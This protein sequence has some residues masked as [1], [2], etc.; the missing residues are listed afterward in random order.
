MILFQ[1][2]FEKRV[3]ELLKENNE[4]VFFVFRG[5]GVEQYTYLVEHENAVLKESNLLKNGYLNLE[6]L[7]QSK[8]KLNKN[9][10]LAEGSLIGFYE[11]LIS[12]LSIS[13]NLSASFEGR[14]V[15]INN[16]LFNKAIPSCLPYEKVSE[17]FD[18]MQSDKVQEQSEMELIGQYYSDAL[19]LNNETALLYLI[20]A[21]K[22]IDLEVRDFFEIKLNGSSSHK[23]K[24][25]VLLGTEHDYLFRLAI[26]DGHA[27]EVNINKDILGEKGI[28]LS[29]QKALECLEIPY[30]MTEID[31]KAPKFEYDAAQFL[32]YLKKYWGENAEFRNLEFYKE[33]SISKE[34]K[35][36]SQGSLIS[37]IVGQCEIAQRDGN[38]RHIFITA[39]TGAGKSLLF[40]LPALYISEQYN[41]VTIVI[42]PLIA[43]MNDQVSQLERE[44]GVQIA[45]CINSSISFD[46][47]IR[48]QVCTIILMYLLRRIEPFQSCRFSN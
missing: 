2:F 48:E 46:N 32:P 20:N 33:P 18:Y 29:L 43:L 21:H 9:L 10:L 45:T 34:I 5:F 27:E 1:K 37:E 7:E 6:V 42:S 26:M 38:F 4:Q 36:Y 17:F 23:P 28:S 31:F 8:K 47:A 16:N 19:I 11:E 25:D 13:R 44:R 39:P 14:V 40:Q 15:V 22:D 35:E 3:A 12:V 41:L 24:K 30:S